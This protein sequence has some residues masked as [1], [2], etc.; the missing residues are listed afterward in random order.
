MRIIDNSG[1]D[2]RIFQVNVTSD[3]QAAFMTEVDSGAPNQ[4]HAVLYLER[5]S[6]SVSISGWPLA[7]AAVLVPFLSLPVSP[8]F[9]GKLT[10][11]APMSLPAVAAMGVVFDGTILGCMMTY[12][13]AFPL[14]F[15]FCSKPVPECP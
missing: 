2:K 10:G 15:T 3:G 4:H 9:L 13:V 8:W 6:T 14:Y 12:V 5:Q 11:E 1:K 7:G